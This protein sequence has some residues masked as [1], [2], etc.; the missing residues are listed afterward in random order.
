MKLQSNWTQWPQIEAEQKREPSDHKHAI[1]PSEQKSE[2]KD[3]ITI[4]WA[5]MHLKVL[6]TVS[7]QTE[8]EWS[9]PEK[10][11]QRSHYNKA[12]H[13]CTWMS[14]TQRL[15]RNLLNIPSVITSP[16]I[17]SMKTKPQHRL[18]R[19]SISLQRELKA[20]TDYSSSK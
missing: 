6:N 5:P 14:W 12:E 9:A 17:G 18:D 15:N 11:K 1:E 10:W 19:D 3:H 16:S 20:I 4:S 8:I 2:K 7:H 13:P